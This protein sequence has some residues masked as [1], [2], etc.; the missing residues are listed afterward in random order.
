[1]AANAGVP[2]V[3]A[4]QGE[5]ARLLAPLEAECLFE[6]GDRAGLARLTTR[7]FDEA[8][9]AARVHDGMQSDFRQRWQVTPGWERTILQLTRGL[10]PSK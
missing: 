3:A 5:P 6:P 2:I 9:V 4:R 10:I 7:M 8:D 1:V